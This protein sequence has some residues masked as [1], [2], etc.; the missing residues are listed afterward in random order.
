MVAFPHATIESRA[1]VSEPPPELLLG[2]IMQAYYGAFSRAD[3]GDDVDESVDD[4]VV[5]G[6][7]AAYDEFLAELTKATERAGQAREHLDER[8]AAVTARVRGA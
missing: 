3:A 7:R 6:I 2:G 5:H 8:L 1:P 4:L